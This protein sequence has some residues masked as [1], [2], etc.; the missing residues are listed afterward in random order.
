MKKKLLALLCGAVF[1]AATLTA[2]EA[3]TRITFAA[4]DNIVVTGRNMDWDKDDLLKVHILPRNV[5]RKSEGNNPLSLGSEVW[6]CGGV[7]F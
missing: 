3:C 5:Q 1:S 6:K 7:F 4:N 2:A